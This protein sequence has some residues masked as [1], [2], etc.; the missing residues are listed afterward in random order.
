MSVLHQDS[1]HRRSGCRKEMSSATPALSLFDIHKPN[2]RLVHQRGGLE[3]LTG[4]LLSHLRL[5][6]MVQ[7]F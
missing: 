7:S 1:P 2:A 4:I 5:H 6:F 3:C